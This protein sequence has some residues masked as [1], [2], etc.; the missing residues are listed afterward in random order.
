[1]EWLEILLPV[2]LPSM[3]WLE[4]LPPVELP[5][6]EVDIELKRN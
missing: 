3:E 4:V 6:M 1:M 2:E 5:P